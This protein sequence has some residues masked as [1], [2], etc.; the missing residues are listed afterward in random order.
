LRA[1]S[2]CKVQALVPSRD[3][4]SIAFLDGRQEAAAVDYTQHPNSVFL[5]C[6]SVNDA[7]RRDDDFAVMAP[8]KLRDRA[9]ALREPS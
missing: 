1:R 5:L 3:K 6:K 7:V 2:G 8:W 4:D 9:A